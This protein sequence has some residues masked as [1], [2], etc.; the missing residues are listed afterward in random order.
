M[1]NSSALYKSPRWKT[2]EETDNARRRPRRGPHR[3]AACRAGAGAGASRGSSCGPG[4]SGLGGMLWPLAP[5]SETLSNLCDAISD[6]NCK[7]CRGGMWEAARAGGNRA[8]SYFKQIILC[9]LI[10][11]GGRGALWRA[12]REIF[13]PG[14]VTLPSNSQHLISSVSLKK[15]SSSLVRSMQR[16]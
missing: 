14:L 2:K 5:V 11:G 6:L 4:R 7:R 15:N 8:C 10:F 16:R 12:G 1:Q 13:V 3:A 9:H